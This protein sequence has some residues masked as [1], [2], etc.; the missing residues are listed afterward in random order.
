MQRSRAAAA[1]PAHPDKATRVFRID[2]TKR[3]LQRRLNFLIRIVRRLAGEKAGQ[4]SSDD[5]AADLRRDLLSQ[6]RP[7]A[8]APRS[9]VLLFH[10]GDDPVE[11]AAGHR[12]LAIAALS[13]LG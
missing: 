13:N 5:C 7:V 1:A 8:A 3:A 2:E 11:L 12:S 4:Q 9:F 6:V 10:V